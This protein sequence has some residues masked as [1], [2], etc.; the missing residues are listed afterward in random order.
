MSGTE[1]IDVVFGAAPGKII[2]FGE[3]AVVHGQPAIAATIERGIRVAVTRRAGAT[4]GPVLRSNNAALPLRSRPDPDG[5]GPERL[6]QALALMRE[7]CGERVRELAFSVDGAIPAGAGLGSSAALSVALVRGVHRFFDED[8]DDATLIERAFA[9]ERVFHG[10]PSGVDHTTIVTG[11]VVAYERG[12]DGAPAKVASLVLPRKV[13]LVVGVAGP[14]AG[15]A[16]AVAALRERARRHP[17]HYARLYDGIGALARSA[18]VHLEKGELSAVGELMDLNQ[19]YLNALGVSTPAIEAMCAIARE[20]GALGAK[21]S[22]AGGGGAV[23][24]LADDAGLDAAAGLVRAW[25]A[26]GYAA[27]ATDLHRVTSNLDKELP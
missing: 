18:R 15:T 8:I 12:V 11:G 21:L 16:N 27:F 25:A 2:L 17:E 10:N 5:E 26:A 24:A 20:R 22:G 14:H 7:L 9:V 13:T 4:D 3:H 19:G 1:P 23:I 6:R